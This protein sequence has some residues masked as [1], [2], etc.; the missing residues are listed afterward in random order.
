MNRFMREFVET[1]GELLGS[2]QVRMMGRWKHHGPITTLDHS[3]FVAY[4]SF[5]AAR[6]LGL[7]EAAAA[8]GGLL[9]D[10]YLYDSK[11]K[12]AHPGWQC[13]DHPRAA[14]RNA[15]ALTRLSSKERNIILSHM[16]PLGGQLPRS[17]EALLVDLVDT[18]CAGLEV[19]RIYHPSRLREKLGVRPLIP[20]G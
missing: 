8:R 16:W 20:A 19:F 12:S 7:D 17:P 1:T 18:F 4:L 14:A 15:E 10:L 6:A 5:R 9:H 13:F 2:D 3:L 11:D